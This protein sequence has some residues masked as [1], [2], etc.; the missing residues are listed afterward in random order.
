MSTITRDP[1]TVGPQGKPLLRLKPKAP[2]QPPEQP[3]VAPAH[4]V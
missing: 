1:A 2:P 3:K 4:P